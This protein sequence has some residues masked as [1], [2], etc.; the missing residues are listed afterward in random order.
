MS[1]PNGNLACSFSFNCQNHSF[2]HLS[3][4]TLGN[5]HGVLWPGKNEG[6]CRIRTDQNSPF[7]FP[8][9]VLVGQREPKL[10]RNSKLVLAVQVSRASP[11]RRAQKPAFI[12]GGIFPKCLAPGS[13]HAGQKRI[14]AVFSS[15]RRTLFIQGRKPGFPSSRSTT[16]RPR[17]RILPLIRL[18]ATDL[19]TMAGRD[20][21]HNKIFF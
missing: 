18:C 12:L 8:A 9:L 20:K 13:F 5:P 10:F 3:F 21:L 4:Y 1:P 11:Q 19:R 14:L 16:S 17:I 6:A 15:A 7:V 2:Q